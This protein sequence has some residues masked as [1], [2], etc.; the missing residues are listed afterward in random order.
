MP[1]ILPKNEQESTNQHYDTSGWLA[2]VHFLEELKVPKSPFEIN[3][4]LG[5][6]LIMFNLI[7]SSDFSWFKDY[8]RLLTSSFTVIAQ[9][10]N[11]CVPHIDFLCDKDFP[12][13]ILEMKFLFS[14][15]EIENKIL[16]ISKMLLSLKKALMPSLNETNK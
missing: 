13:A 12:A 15:V 14:Y 3:W 10:L 16:S 9:I 6:Q 7:I 4:P 11:K 1:S 2:F 5:M 8:A